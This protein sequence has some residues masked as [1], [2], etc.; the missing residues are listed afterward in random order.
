MCTI[1]GDRAC[2]GRLLTFLYVRYSL[3]IVTEHECNTFDRSYRH[4]GQPNQL[5]G[6]PYLVRVALVP[7]A[8]LFLFFFPCVPYLLLAVRFF[9][10]FENFGRTYCGR[11]L[12]FSFRVSRFHFGAL[13]SPPVHLPPMLPRPQLDTSTVLALLYRPF[14]PDLCQ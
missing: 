12:R 6:L 10:T 4:T 1:P 5:P 13:S 8:P 14:P 3:W 2:S 9:A 11:H 7:L